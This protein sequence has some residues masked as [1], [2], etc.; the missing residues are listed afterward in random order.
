MKHP[1]ENLRALGYD[2][3][4]SA[5]NIIYSYTGTALPPAAEAGAM[6]SELRRNKDE[7]ISYLQKSFAR[8]PS[9]GLSILSPASPYNDIE[10]RNRD[11]GIVD[12]HWETPRWLYEKLNGEFKFDCDPCPLHAD[13]DGLAREWGMSNF[14][15]PPY[16]RTD[17]PRFIKRAFEEWR[18]GATCVL[19][20]PA[21]VS[22]ADFHD[23]IYPHAAEIR[24]IRGRVAFGGTNTKGERVTTKKGKHDSMLVI[25]R[26]ASVKPSAPMASSE[27]TPEYSSW[28]VYQP[29]T[30]R[31]PLWQE[32]PSPMVPP[33]KRAEG[34]PP[35]Q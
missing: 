34:T 31:T 26:G 29:P 2:V 27:L 25:F 16:N 14:V 24:F 23:L 6:L 22:T 33:Q 15:N 3:G 7:A 18:K 30:H 35:C 32:G 8:T 28:S 5:G 19:L 9:Q 4:L 17:K 21:A 13:F 20:I 12:D 1:V 10:K 11:G